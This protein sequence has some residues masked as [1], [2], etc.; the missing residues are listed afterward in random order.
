MGRVPIRLY[1]DSVLK[2]RAEPVTKVTDELRQLAADMFETMDAARGVGLAA[3]QVGVLQRLITISVPKVGDD[4]PA[5]RAALI[6]PEVVE[7]SGT[8]SGEEGCL[9]FPGLYFEVRRAKVCKVRALDLDGKPMEVEATGY[10]ARALLHEIDHLDGVLYI[11]RITT[12]RR[13]LLRGKLDSIRRR[14]SL[15]ETRGEDE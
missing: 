15:G 3:N 13:S 9:S 2:N 4:Q 7:T 14:G 8:Q 11:D 6:N 5:F 1:G 10:L 12:V